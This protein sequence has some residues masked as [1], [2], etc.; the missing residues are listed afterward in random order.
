[1]R[2]LKA[3]PRTDWSKVNIAALREHLIDMNEVTLQAGAETP[4]SR[5]HGPD[6]AGRTS[7]GS[8]F[9]YG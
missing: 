6:S 3:N 7:P 5:L 2:L 1:M 9:G 4:V 8:S